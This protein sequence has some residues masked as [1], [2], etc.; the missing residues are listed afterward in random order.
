M[1]GADRGELVHDGQRPVDAA[2]AVAQEH[3]G[4]VD[5]RRLEGL[6]AHAQRRLGV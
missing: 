6:A 5:A 2:V 1:R 3:A 4:E